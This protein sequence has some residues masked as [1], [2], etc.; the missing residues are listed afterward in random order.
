MEGIEVARK[1]APEA[2]V[3]ICPTDS[4]SVRDEQSELEPRPVGF[5]KTLWKTAEA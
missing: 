5:I 4:E 2:E 3:H 1:I